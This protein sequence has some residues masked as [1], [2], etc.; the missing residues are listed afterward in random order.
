MSLIKEQ[1]ITSKSVVGGTEDLYYCYFTFNSGNSL[2]F[3]I[4]YW[5]LKQCGLMSINGVQSAVRA[6][7][8]EIEE[9]LQVVIGGIGIYSEAGNIM[10]SISETYWKHAKDRPEKETLYAYLVNHPNTRIIHQMR[11]NAHPSGYGNGGNHM[12]ICM[13]HL[14]PDQVGYDKA[15]DYGT[16]ELLELKPNAK[17]T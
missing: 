1:K 3:T 16:T 13:L 5:A 14:Y 10:F 8:Q 4:G 7:K 2:A 11:N 17:Q 6:T 9:A 12:L 15:G